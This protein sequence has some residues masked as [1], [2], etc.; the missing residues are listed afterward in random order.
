M[1]K[2]LKTIRELRNMP[3]I[4]REGYFATL[5]DSERRNLMKK[6]AESSI[7]LGLTQH[8]NS[9]SINMLISPNKDAMIFYEESRYN[10]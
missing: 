8:D 9:V 10:G 5:S 1:G 7:T 3:V 2:K 6:F 4:I